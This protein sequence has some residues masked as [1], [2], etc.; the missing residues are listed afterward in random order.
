MRSFQEQEFHI[1]REKAATK[2]LR[3]TPP[4]TLQ[5]QEKIVDPFTS[6]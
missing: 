2:L 6:W 5:G 4:L 3:S 1:S